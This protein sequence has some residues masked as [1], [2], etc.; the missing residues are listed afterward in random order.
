MGALCTGALCVVGALCV[1]G[2]LCVAA[3]VL[4]V[5]CLCGA[6]RSAG[7]LLGA[8][9][10]ATFGACDGSATTGARA[11]AAGEEEDFFA[12]R[13]IPNAAAKATTAAIRSGTI[14]NGRAAVMAA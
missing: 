6:A 9:S 10:A 7:R 1:A 5:F 13:P 11:G 8:V 4:R 3:G 14:G 2:V 12:A